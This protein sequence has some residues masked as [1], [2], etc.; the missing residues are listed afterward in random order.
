[1]SCE[2]I[3]LC[4]VRCTDWSLSVAIDCD[5][6]NAIWDSSSLELEI[7][8]MANA[9]VYVQTLTTDA[10]V[11]N[12]ILEIPNSVTCTFLDSSYKYAIK[13]ID[14]DGKVCYIARGLITVEGVTDV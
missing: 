3:N 13:Y 6:S 12:Q 9:S 5:A 2:T 7:F 14:I 11:D 8:N 1:M 10:N 4:Q